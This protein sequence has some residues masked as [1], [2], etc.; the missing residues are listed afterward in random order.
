MTYTPD[1]NKK[2]ALLEIFK[3][4]VWLTLLPDGQQELESAFA[5]GSAQ[6]IDDQDLKWIEDADAQLENGGGTFGCKPI[7]SSKGFYQ[8]STP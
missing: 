7:Y 6:G 5:A 2:P 8:P 4:A 3:A 1:A